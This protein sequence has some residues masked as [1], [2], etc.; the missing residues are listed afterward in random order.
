MGCLFRMSCCVN[1]KKNNLLEWVLLKHCEIWKSLVISLY[2][3]ILWGK[4]KF[5][6]IPPERVKR[7]QRVCTPLSSLSDIPVWGRVYTSDKVQRKSLHS[8]SSCIVSLTLQCSRVESD[9]V[10][11]RRER[12]CTSTRTQRSSA[13]ASRGNRSVLTTARFFCF[14]KKNDYCYTVQQLLECSF[15]LLRPYFHFHN[16]SFYMSD[17]NRDQH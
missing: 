1:H 10:I 4:N 7:N 8:G 12:T 3:F 15:P 2:P 11:Q 17:A 5:P 9:T 13:K 6:F 16:F 14:F